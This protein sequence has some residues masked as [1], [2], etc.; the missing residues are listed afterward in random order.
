MYGVEVYF[1]TSQSE[2]R[3]S[4]E[5]HGEEVSAARSEKKANES[6]DINSEDE[7]SGGLVIENEDE[8]KSDYNHES[9]NWKRRYH[10]VVLAKNQKG[11]Q[12]L[13]TGIQHLFL[14]IHH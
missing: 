5:A 2:W 1:V 7:V 12:N 14:I 3:T 9:N 13:F 4:Y 11:L 10:L 6:T 8:T